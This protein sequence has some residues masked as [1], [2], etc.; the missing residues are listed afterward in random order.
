MNPDKKQT[1]GSAAEALPA[2]TGPA[3][4]DDAALRAALKNTILSASGWRKV[5]APGGEE[6]SSPVPEPVNLLLALAM[7]RAWGSWLRKNLPDADSPNF[8]PLVVTATD[9]RPTGPVLAEMVMQGLE[10]AGCRVRYAGIASAPEIM[11]HSARSAD[12]H[13]FAYISASHNPVG[14]N[15]VKFGTGGG[16]IDK[17]AAAGLIEA[18][19]TIVTAPGAARNLISMLPGNLPLEVPPEVRAVDT[20]E[21]KA[22]L[23]GYQALLQTIAEGPAPAQSAPA[24]N[25]ALLASLRKAIAARP[26]GIVADLNGS[27]RTL[28]ADR[29]YLEYLG[30]QFRTFNDTPGEIAHTIIPEGES[31]EPCRKVLEKAHRENPAFILGYVPDNDGDRGNLVI[32]D[33]SISAARRLEAQEVFSLSVLAELACAEWNRQKTSAGQPPSAIV[34]NGPTSH[35][36]RLIAAAYNAEVHEA[37]VGEANVVNRAAEL[38]KK[39]YQVRILGEGSNGGTIV[40]PAAVRD[41][42]NTITAILKLL[43]LPSSAEQPGPFEDWCRRIKRPEA[44]HPGFGPADILSTLPEFTTTPGSSP[45]ALAEVNVSSHARLKSAWED[46][47][48]K[49]WEQKK[50]QLKKDYGF[51]SW[52]E[53]NNEG[54]QSR[55]GRGSSVR[56]GAQTG[57]LKVV[58]KDARGADAGFLWMRGSQTEPVFRIMAEIK[59]NNPEAEKA[60][61]EWQKSLVERASAAAC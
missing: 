21:K 20:A 47:F 28:S 59:G 61:A 22:A 11:A 5:F 16:V 30:V 7:G 29:S 37:E 1:G 50:E 13:A 51:V 3:V 15:G 60:L 43:R 49:E 35:R 2:S 23:A 53:I 32:W 27:A 6:D 33:Q 54:T 42:L 38:R 10:N 41:P 52:E 44:C 34:V 45:R 8:R 39:G 14:H 25:P 36:V 31:L 48:Q 12:I 9:T 56:S 18:F 55:K 26:V 17:K 57:G 46:L 40:H 19:R 58:F 24:G 4:V